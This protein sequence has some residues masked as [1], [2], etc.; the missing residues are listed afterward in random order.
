M[1]LSVYLGI[2]QYF[3]VFHYADQLEDVRNQLDS[4]IT[5]KEQ[6]EGKSR[7]LQAE[8]GALH[9]MEKSYGKLDKAKRKMEEDLALYRVG[10][11]SPAVLSY[12][13]LCF[14]AIRR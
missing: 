9:S 1:K 5:M 7:Q 2:Y 8:L 12:G 14:W 3:P 13:I 6:L 11:F 10:I 4:E